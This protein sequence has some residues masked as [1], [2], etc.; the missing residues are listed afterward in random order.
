MAAE[1]IRVLA[2][3]VES[4][5]PG[6][7]DPANGIDPA[8]IA[9]QLTEFDGYDIVALVEVG[10][11]NF[12]LF[13]QA[14][15]ADENAPFAEFHTETGRDDRM[16]IIYNT[17]RLELL[18]EPVELTEHEGIKLNDQGRDG[19]WRFRSP[20]VGRFK[21][22]QSDHEFLFNVNHLARGD[23]GVRKVQADGLREWARD[24]DVL[25]IS[26]GD[27]NF[28]FEINEN[29]GNDGFDAML[30]GGVWTWVRPAKL[31]DTNWADIDSRLP[32]DQRRDRYPGSI[33]DFVF[34]ANNTNGWPVQSEVIV[35]EGDFP[36]TGQ[37]SDHRPITCVVEFGGT[38]VKPPAPPSTDSESAAHPARPAEP[39]L[40]SPRYTAIP[41][42][43][44][45]VFYVIDC[46]TGRAWAMIRDESGHHWKDLGT[47]PGK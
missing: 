1:A 23:A 11:E 10:A 17:N 31:I 24:Q 38:P 25:V 40:R 29:R 30:A 45:F 3:N 13:H 6:G 44:A 26:A 12:S 14:V 18:G 37:S 27:F 9:G 5:A 21:V 4:G 20:L 43:G 7:R 39:D 8:T 2:W 19:A 42:E 28:D 32:V 46:E 16:M 34:I 22:R 35:R 15:G 36:D 47:P 41:G 33:L